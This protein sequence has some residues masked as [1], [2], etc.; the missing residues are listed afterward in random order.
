MPCSKEEYV[1]VD[2]PYDMGELCNQVMR[3]ELFRFLQVDIHIQDEFINKFSKF[4]PLLV[5]DSILDELIP[6][7]MREYQTRTG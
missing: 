5:V 7:H 6:S 4:W 1:E 2:Q 3:R